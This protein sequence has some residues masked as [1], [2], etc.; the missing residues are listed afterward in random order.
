MINVDCNFDLRKNKNKEVTWF[1]IKVYS[2]RVF[3][4]FATCMFLLFLN[5]KTK[6]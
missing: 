6:N 2:E 4:I 1:E 3:L 5:D